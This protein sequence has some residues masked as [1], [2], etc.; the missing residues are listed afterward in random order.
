MKYKIANL[1]SR[2][3]FSHEI[4]PVFNEEDMDLDLDPVPYVSRD[5]IDALFQ[6]LETD[7]RAFRAAHSGSKELEL[8]E[9]QFFYLKGRYP[10]LEGR[11][12]EGVGN[13][14]WVIETSRRL[15]RVDYTL[16]GY[17]QLIF[18]FIQI[19]DADGMKQNLDLALDLAVQENNHREIG[20]LLRLQGLYHMITGNYEQAEKRLLESIN[21]LTVTES[22]ARSY[23]VNIAASYN[24]IG[25]ILM[26]KEDYVQALPMFSKAISLC[27]GNV[28]SSLSVFYIN[29]GKAS[30]FQRDYAAAQAF[31]EKALALYG[32]FDSFW[33]RPTLNS[34]L[35]LTLVE[36]R[37]LP[38][39]R[40][41]L[42]AAQKYMWQ[43]KNPSDQGSVFFSQALIRTL[44][45]REPDVGRFFDEILPDSAL[46]YGRLALKHLSRWLDRPEINSLRRL[47]PEL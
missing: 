13:I 24:Y 33:R 36:N 11:Y 45:D 8:L 14:T 34:Y 20:V 35:A 30:F 38:A 39:A 1:N 9:M 26:E 28:F 31:L 41:H 4:F 22:M 46:D 6:N 42:L 2:L 21:A 19:D 16:A 23:T 5:R 44:A 7:I 3:N 18:Y 47:F 15:G 29:A 37:N 17:K 43:M 10:I 40:R 12:E 25:E 32:Q 27:P